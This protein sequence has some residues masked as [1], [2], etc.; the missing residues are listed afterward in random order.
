MP[1]F[2]SLLCLSIIPK[3]IPAKSTHPYKYYCAF[4]IQ[5][6]CSGKV[7]SVWGWLLGKLG[8]SWTIAHLLHNCTKNY[9]RHV[10]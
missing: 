2:C 3:I 10:E 7:T 6:T 8:P 1:A 4:S 9:E 5:C